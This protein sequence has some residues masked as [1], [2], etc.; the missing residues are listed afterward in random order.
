MAAG[1][2]DYWEQEAA[3]KTE[4]EVQVSFMTEYQILPRAN[5]SNADIAEF[6]GVNVGRIHVLSQGLVLR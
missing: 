3:E 5:H 6:A 2:L 1:A 4:Q